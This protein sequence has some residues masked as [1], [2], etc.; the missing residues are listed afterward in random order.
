[1]K[2]LITGVLLFSSMAFCFAEGITE[3]VASAEEDRDM[4]YSFG[5]LI[6][7]DLKSTGLK[8]NYGAFTQGLIAV[9]EDQPSRFSMTEATAQVRIAFQA[10]LAEQA[11]IAREEEARFFAENAFKPGVI[12]TE[13]GLQYEVLVP[14]TGEEPTPDSRVTVNYQGF[15][16]DGTIFDSSQGE[17]VEFPLNQVIPGWSEGIRLMRVG[18]KNRLYIPSALAYGS[19]GAS[20]VIPPYATLIFEVE[21]LGVNAQE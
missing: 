12:S 20:D 13:T 21:L 15:F 1:M 19:Q 6:G 7:Q 14:G 3:N 10:V 8:F 17:P 9:M 5:M 16:R 4:S 18:G 2:K 11:E